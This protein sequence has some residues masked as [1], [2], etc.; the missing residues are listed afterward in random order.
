MVV[1]L[2]YICVMLISDKLTVDVINTGG[3]TD[4]Y[5]IIQ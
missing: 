1:V 3:K 2:L 5:N 4:E